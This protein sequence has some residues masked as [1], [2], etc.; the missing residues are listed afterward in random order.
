MEII[1]A[2]I[3]WILCLSVSFY[4]LRKAWR[5]RYRYV[6]IADLPVRIRGQ[7]KRIL[8]GQAVEF[9]LIAWNLGLLPDDVNWY[10]QNGLMK[11]A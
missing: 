9:N 7:G 1:I 5:T 4:M 10:I 3:I 6:A 2:S 8:K 11:R